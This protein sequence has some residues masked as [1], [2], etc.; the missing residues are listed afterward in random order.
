MAAPCPEI[1]ICTYR[2]ACLLLRGPAAIPTPC[3]PNPDGITNKMINFTDRISVVL[4][5]PQNPGNIGMVCRAMKNMGMSDLRLVKGCSREHPEAYKFAV[6]ARDLLENARSF[7]SLQDALADREITIATT[8]RHGKYRQEIYSPAEIAEKVCSEMGDNSASLVFGREDNGLTTEE[9]Q[10]CRWHATI[11]SSE[12]YG[13]LNLAQSVLIFC[14]ELF[15]ETRRS[16]LAGSRTFAPVSELEDLY[17]H[18]ET[19]LLGIGFLNAQNPAHLM[20]SLRRIFARAGLDSRE[21][22]ILRG[23]MSQVDWASERPSEAEIS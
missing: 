18:M 12:E 19:T 22:A 5:E 6:S 4:V 10:L 20:R 2:P 14:Y 17:G 21:V 9:L 16:T 1:Q 8:R 23:M 13:S 11:P 3:R 7:D 15:K